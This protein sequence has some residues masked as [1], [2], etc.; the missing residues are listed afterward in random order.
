VQPTDSHSRTAARAKSPDCSDVTAAE[1]T[2]DLASSATLPALQEKRGCGTFCGSAL[3]EKRGCGT[4]CGFRLPE[5]S[6]MIAGHASDT[7]R[8]SSD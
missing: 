7:P 2:A 4:F 1:T 5:L 8:A 3:Q 6:Q